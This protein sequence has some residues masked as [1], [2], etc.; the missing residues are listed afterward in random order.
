M[1]D[2]RYRR[3]VSGRTNN[4]GLLLSFRFSRRSRASSL[5]QVCLKRKVLDTPVAYDVGN[6]ETNTQAHPNVQT[7]TNSLSSIS[8]AASGL[9]PYS[10]HLYSLP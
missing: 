9:S 2:A 7:E 6:A 8:F 10:T 5:P 4:A 1:H 3:G